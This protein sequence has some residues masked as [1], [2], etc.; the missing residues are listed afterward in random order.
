MT[1]TPLE[2]PVEAPKNTHGGGNLPNTPLTVSIISFLL[3]SLF[4]IGFTT[5][6]I[7]GSAQLWWATPQLGFFV[8]SWAAFHWAEFAVTAGWNRERCNVDCE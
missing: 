5:F 4:T 3:G 2:M 8:A 1:T 7:G 6:L